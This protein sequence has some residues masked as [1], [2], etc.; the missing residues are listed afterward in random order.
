MSHGARE[1]VTIALF[2]SMFGLRPVERGVADRLRAAGH[3]VVAPDLFAG[4]VADRA[5]P[6]WEDGFAL[7]EDVGWETIVKRARAAVRDLPPETVLCGLSMGV[8][9]IGSLWPERLEA[10]GAI[11]LHAPTTVPEGVPEGTPVQLHIGV[12]DPF[13]PEDQLAAFRDSAARA[14]ADAALYSYPGAGHFFTDPE[15]PDHDPGAADCA[16]RRASTLLAKAQCAVS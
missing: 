16:W 15:L 2:H 5:V 8:G 9:V 1:P 13:A 4:A 11:L 10:A 12:G 6:R 14:G 3:V 7:M